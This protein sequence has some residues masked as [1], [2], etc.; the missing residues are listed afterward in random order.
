MLYKITYLSNKD[1]NIYKAKSNKSDDQEKQYQQIQSINAF[2]IQNRR[3]NKNIVF[4][5]TRIPKNRMLLMD[6]LTS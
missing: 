6:I 1:D 3:L 2:N 5:E 4:I